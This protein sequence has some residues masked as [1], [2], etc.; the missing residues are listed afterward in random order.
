MQGLGKRINWTLGKKGTTR[1]KVYVDGT[2][3]L[4]DYVHPGHIRKVVRDDLRI[5]TRDEADKRIRIWVH[6][7]D[8]TANYLEW[9]YQ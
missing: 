3:M 7:I 2:K 8:L 5:K 1:F 6:D 9:I 4:D